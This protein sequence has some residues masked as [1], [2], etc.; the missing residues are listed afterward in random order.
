[1]HSPISFCGNDDDTAPLIESSGDDDESVDGRTFR[2]YKPVYLWLKLLKRYK[3]ENETDDDDTTTTCSTTT[4]TTTATTT[5][6]TT[7]D[8]EET[9]DEN[10]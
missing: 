2:S 7:E 4:T 1:M 8:E 10:C 9:E 3:D 6:T 5:T